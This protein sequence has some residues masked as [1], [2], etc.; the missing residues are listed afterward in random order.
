M[1]RVEEQRVW[2]GANPTRKGFGFGDL[3]KDQL[4][5]AAWGALQRP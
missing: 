5:T 2:A 3:S 4:L 1:I